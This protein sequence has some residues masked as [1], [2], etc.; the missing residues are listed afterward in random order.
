MSAQC[1][2]C[3]LTV[4]EHTQA[5][6]RRLSG[7]DDMRQRIQGVLMPYAM[8]QTKEKCWKQLPMQSHL[9]RCCTRDWLTPSWELPVL[10]VSVR[11]VTVKNHTSFSGSKLCNIL[12]LD[13]VH[14]PMDKISQAPTS[15]FYLPPN[16][17]FLVKSDF[18]RTSYRRSFF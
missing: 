2:K 15:C 9:M 17:A 13:R 16:L 11:S 3:H 1:H 6:Q 18:I 14:A 7:I 10:W 4:S 12:S 5:A 8:I